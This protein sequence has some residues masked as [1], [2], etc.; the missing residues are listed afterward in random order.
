MRDLQDANRR[1]KIIII[2]FLGVGLHR[3]TVICELTRGCII[4]YATAGMSS[5]GIQDAE[6]SMLEFHCYRVQ[7]APVGV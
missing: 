5:T 6:R 3:V 7:L 2:F 1:M 4:L